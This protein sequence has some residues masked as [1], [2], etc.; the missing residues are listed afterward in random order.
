MKHTLISLLSLS[1]RIPV[2]LF[3]WLSLSPSLPLF[4]ERFHC[5]LIHN[6]VFSSLHTF[7]G[8][9][10]RFCLSF[11]YHFYS[12]ALMI[13]LMV[14]AHSALSRCSSYL[15]IQYFLFLESINVFALTC[16]WRFSKVPLGLA[17]VTWWF[18]MWRSCLAFQL[19]GSFRH[20]SDLII[21]FSLLSS[22][23]LRWFNITL[24][25]QW[26]SLY[27]VKIILAVGIGISIWF[28]IRFMV[29]VK[30]RFTLGS[31]A[32]VKNSLRAGC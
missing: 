20:V 27:F 19:W 2:S 26:A 15:I 22:S 14:S 17:I 29:R 32:E 4:L 11:F 30:V 10:P 5:F 28:Q 18:R 9:Y 7:N 12:N 16:R 31:R 13:K 23:N 21:T 24:A 1:L 6:F 3:I 8:W 25:K